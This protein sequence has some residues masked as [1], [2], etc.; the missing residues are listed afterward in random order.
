MNDRLDKLNQYFHFCD[1]HPSQDKL[2]YVWSFTERISQ[3]LK[4]QYHP[5]YETTIDEAMI[6]FTG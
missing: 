4:L 2:A 3:N 6:A 1:G 5:H